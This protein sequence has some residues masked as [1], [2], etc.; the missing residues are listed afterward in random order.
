MAMITYQIYDP[1]YKLMAS[2]VAYTS[3]SE[4][5]ETVKR[6]DHDK[7]RELAFAL[8]IPGGSRVEIAVYSQSL[9]MPN[10][11]KVRQ[12]YQSIWI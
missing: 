5:V 12:Y 7:V 2:D 1:D 8:D 9:D 11:A 10:A 3:N 6:I 4:R